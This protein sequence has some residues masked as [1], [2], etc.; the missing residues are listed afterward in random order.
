MSI[1]R[2]PSSPERDWTDIEVTPRDPG[3]EKYFLKRIEVE[4]A[5]SVVYTVRDGRRTGYV[6]IERC[7][8]IQ[9]IELGVQV[10][11]PELP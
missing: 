1:A 8:F 9:F 10:D 7:E 11:V 4:I 2:Y 3:L 5:G 6:P